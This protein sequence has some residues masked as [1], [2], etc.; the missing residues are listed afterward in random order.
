MGHAW[1]AA[2]LRKKKDGDVGM[3]YSKL[4]ASA[5]ASVL[6]VTY[7]NKNTGEIVSRG[8][9]SVI[10]DGSM[11]LTCCHCCAKNTE[12]YATGIL[13]GENRIVGEIRYAFPNIDIAVL[14]FQ[15][16]VGTSLEI[17]DS[18]SLEIG[19]EVF[20]IGFPFGREKGLVAGHV[21]AFERDGKIRLDAA[22]NPG[23][24]GGPLFTAEGLIVGVVDAKSGSITASLKSIQGR[25][26][27][28]GVSI[29]GVDVI[30]TIE[31]ILFCMEQNLN[32][33]IGYAVPVGMFPD[34]LK[35]LWATIHT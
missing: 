20:T 29:G 15:E 10:G 33:G 24:S 28:A 35:Q 30:Q 8:S 9:G 16:P 25:R 21:S 14:K 17:G 1:P 34:S 27:N 19:S 2:V 12:Q 23:N 7:W 26:R 4:Y 32:A 18:D 13:D 3:D 11:V 5:E 22:V 31:D 6:Q